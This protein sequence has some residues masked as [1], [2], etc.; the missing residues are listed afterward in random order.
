VGGRR[1]ASF[2]SRIAPTA[3]NSFVGAVGVAR[4]CARVYR[5]S[6]THARTR[7]RLPRSE[8]R[9]GSQRWPSV[10]TGA[11]SMARLNRRTWAGEHT[12]TPADRAHAITCFRP[13]HTWT[14]MCGHVRAGQASRGASDRRDAVRG[15]EHSPRDTRGRSPH[16]PQPL[17]HS[18]ANGR[19]TRRDDYSGEPLRRGPGVASRGGRGYTV[20]TTEAH[21]GVRRMDGGSR[22]EGVLGGWVCVR[23]T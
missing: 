23:H 11:T 7:T 17:A 5:Y 1:V 15:R 3:I 6:R 12:C 20:A 14:R 9:S 8:V 21:G 18:L 10:T 22:G 2:S 13:R 4:T 19:R 16:Y